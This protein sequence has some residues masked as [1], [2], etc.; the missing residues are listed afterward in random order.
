MCY[1]G[2]RF[3]E[4]A[5][6]KL[7]DIHLAE[8]YMIGGIKTEAG[9]DRQIPIH[10]KIKPLI[11]ELMLKRKKKLLEIERNCFYTHYWEAIRRTGVRQLPP[12]TCRHYFFSR[13]T[14]AGIQGGIIAEIGG[15]SN[16]LITVRNYVNTPLNDKI[17]AVNK[18]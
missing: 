3:G 9:T 4:L 5:K 1:S 7:S 18:I 8:N 15:H 17:D 10:A 16:Y 11:A 13:L 12:H 14:S 6:I 2:M